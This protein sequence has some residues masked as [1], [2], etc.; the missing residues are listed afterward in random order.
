METETH[1]REVAEAA[2]R[3]GLSRNVAERVAASRFGPPRE[4]AAA[5]AA[6]R[7]PTP[8]S[9]AGTLGWAALA[10]AGAGLA[11][12]GVSGL[13][14]AL[15]NG[16]VGSRF[17]GALPAT[18]PA[19]VWSSYL[20]AHPT[21]RSTCPSSMAALAWASTSAVR[22]HRFLR[23]CWRRPWPTGACATYARGDW[24]ARSDR[25]RVAPVTDVMPGR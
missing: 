4:V 12:I 6:T 2:E 19:A 20:A 15:A 5:E 8:V 9:A 22:W 16:T 14:V 17:V 21:A 13:L 1:L 24:S 3:A 23:P 11:A 25:P 10:L 7:G 18:Y